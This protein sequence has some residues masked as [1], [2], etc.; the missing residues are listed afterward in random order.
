MEGI[1]DFGSM[2]K[3]ILAEGANIDWF[4]SL[5]YNPHKKKHSGIGTV[6]LKWLKD[7]GVLTCAGVGNNAGYWDKG[8]FYQNFMEC[9]ETQDAN[10]RRRKSSA[11]S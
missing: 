7:E 6:S 11:E 3:L 4:R 10:R 2:A 1:I 5:K 9:M 8:R